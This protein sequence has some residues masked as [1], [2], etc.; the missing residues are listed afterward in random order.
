MFPQSGRSSV[1]LDQT[2]ES[3]NHSPLR[4]TPTPQAQISKRDFQRNELHVRN[5]RELRTPVGG[6]RI[7]PAFAPDTEE[8][9]EELT[10]TRHAQNSLGHHFA[11]QSHLN[12]LH[13]SN[14]L[15]YTQV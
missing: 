5:D 1:V 13:G 12:L 7:N 10:P 14:L 3:G 8:E 6:A 9:D 2:I 11:S 4:Q 15:E